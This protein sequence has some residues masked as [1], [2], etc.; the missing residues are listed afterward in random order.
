MNKNPI[1]I[2]TVK[3]QLG[4]IEKS[5]DYVFDAYKPYI[6]AGLKS[7]AFINKYKDLKILPK[8]VEKILTVLNEKERKE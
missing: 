6:I 1:K 7:E 4:N 5:V 2:R 3:R 8:K